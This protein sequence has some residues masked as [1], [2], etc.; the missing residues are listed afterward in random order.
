MLKMYQLGSRHSGASTEFWDETWKGTSFEDALRFCEV[1]PLRPLF[2]RFA[3]PGSKMLEGG[4]GQGHYVAYYGSRGVQTLGLDFAQPSLHR[5]HAYD[6]RLMSCAGDVAALPFSDASF[7][8]YYSGGVVEHFENGAE[9]ALNEAF[10]VLRPG[11]VLLISVPYNSPLRKT[12]LPLKVGRWKRVRQPQVDAKGNRDDLQFFQYAYSQNEFKKM[13]ESAKLRVIDTQG[14]GI[15]W[16]LCD[17]RMLQV[18]VEK[19]TRRM[20]S[21]RI[22]QAAGPT[23][24]VDGADADCLMSVSCSTDANQPSPDVSPIR[25]LLKRLMVSEDDKVPLIGLGV[26]LLRWACA[27]MMMYVCVREK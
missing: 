6:P 1:D 26:R 2:E 8:V 18:Q 25:Q 14:Y 11:G 12:L 15:L 9:P 27:N 19:L 10:R 24:V 4:C 21:N 3:K 17:L 22:L 13:L 5:L 23:G 20:A 16:G 7:D